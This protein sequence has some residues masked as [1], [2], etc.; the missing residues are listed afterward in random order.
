MLPTEQMHPSPTFRPWS[1]ALFTE[2]QRLPDPGLWG[3]EQWASRRGTAS[4][5]GS[6]PCCRKAANATSGS[7]GL[8]RQKPSHMIRQHITSKRGETGTKV[9][10]SP[11]SPSL[12]GY[13][14]AGLR[15][16]MLLAQPCQ[17]LSSAEK[18]PAGQQQQKTVLLW[19]TMAPVPQGIC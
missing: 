11:P 4:S 16:S 19:A 15:V 6:Q 3:S 17:C 1:R 7:C 12:P 13:F 18:I 10:A 2:H 5:V 14:R 8:T 9:P